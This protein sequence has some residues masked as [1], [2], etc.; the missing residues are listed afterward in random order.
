MS[1]SWEISAV[2]QHGGRKICL[3]PSKSAILS[4]KVLPLCQVHQVPSHELNF[5]LLAFE[6]SWIISACYLF[7][8]CLAVA[9]HDSSASSKI[10]NKHKYAQIRQLNTMQAKWNQSHMMSLG[11]LKIVVYMTVSY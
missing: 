9:V 4:Q 10:N 7:L 6:Q 5:A 3:I 8:S 11:I 2:C 1:A